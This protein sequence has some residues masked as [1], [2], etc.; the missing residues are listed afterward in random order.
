MAT[1]YESG[2]TPAQNMRNFEPS[3]TY[4]FHEDKKQ[5][6]SLDFTQRIE[7]ALARYNA[8][9]NVFKRWLFE[10]LSW[11]VSASC[12]VAI[13]LIN[14]RIKSKPMVQ[15]PS[16]LNWINVLGKISSAA[17]IVPTTE[18]LGQ[19]KW[20]WFHKSKAMWDFEI[21]DKASRGPLGAL[22]LLYRTKGRS[23]AALGALLIVLLLAID[24]FFQQVVDLPDRWKLHASSGVLPRTIH[25]VGQVPNAYVDGVEMLSDDKDMFHTVEKFAYGNGT[26]PVPFGNG[27]RPDIPLSC[28]TS[29][30]TWPVYD[31]LGVCSQCADIS[32]HLDFACMVNT[33]DWTSSLSGGFMVEGGYPNATMCGY[34]LNITSHNP[35]LMSGYIVN[36][37]TSAYSE[38]LIMRTLPLTT[39]LL[40]E[41]LY[42]NG[43][44]NFKEFRNTIQD[45]L[46]VSAVNGSAASVHR[47]ETP[48][49]QECVLT[50]C[51]KTMQ[52]SYSLGEY[53]EEILETFI[54]TTSGP[55]PWIASSF[56]DGTSNGT[57]SFFL[58]DIHIDIGITPSGRN[59]SGYGMANSSVASITVGFTD[60]FPAFATVMN[61]SSV[62]LLRYKTWMANVAWNRILDFNPWISP[63]NVT[64][65]MERFATAMTNIIRSSENMEMLSGDAW[66]METFISVR[67]AWLSFPFIL[68]VLTLVFLVSTIMKT[69]KDNETRLFKNSAMP[70]LIYGLPKE[71]QGQF[72]NSSTWNSTKETKKVRIRLNPKTG[73]RV[74]GQ[75]QLST[76]P[77]LPRPAV[78]PHHS[79]I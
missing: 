39:T 25:Y 1:Q 58:Q 10:T 2:D 9:D 52:S 34:F 19:L 31:T 69:S 42:G 57:D 21:F 3:T 23:L 64:R 41:P 20:N 44:I 68:L 38:T 74:S 12:M 54:N 50:W 4:L 49:A 43:S 15:E 79:W 16:S 47:N 75:S 22:M 40:H 59:I 30:C 66:V 14:L 18:A 13:I 11:L 70:T 26:Q 46:I 24:T 76:S 77:Q 67:W 48:I 56:S 37:N 5:K 45:V 36:S 53:K 71:T 29:N 32:E 73:W 78:Q 65:H 63:N 55:W 51:V 6:P 61:E 33:V 7:R 17:L 72:T 27:T 8:S 35:I 62:P 60:V 28:P